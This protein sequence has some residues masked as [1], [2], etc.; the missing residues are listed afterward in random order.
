MSVR[1]ALALSRTPALGFVV[2]GLYWGG[3]ATLVP[4]LKARI[5]AS[6]AQFGLL[7]L[8]TSIGLL[9]T[10]VLAPALDRA[11]GQ[12][13]MV[14]AAVAL[15]AAFLAPGLVVTPLGFFVAMIFCGMASGMLDVIMNARVSELETAHARPL[16]NANHGVFSVAYACAA[17]GTGLAREAALPPVAVFLVI[18]GL[19]LSF[20]WRMRMAPAPVDEAP[21]GA[22]GF[23]YGVVLLCGAIVLVAFMTEASVEA[24]SALHIERTLGGRA[25]EGALGPAML[26]ITMAVGR[27]GGQAVSERMSDLAVIFAGCALA[28]MGVSFVALAQVTWVAY[29]GFGMM[30]LGVSAIGPIGL[31]LVGRMVPPHVRTKAISRA[32]VMGFFGFFLA[33]AAMGVISEGFG[34]R[35]AF[36]AIGVLLLALIPLALEIRRRGP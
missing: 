21:E 19:V 3:L 6:D 27:F 30:G 36:A 26:G 20:A 28:V 17:L 8:G 9:T 34:L 18:G 2:V 4:E 15:A 31:A 33:P 7:L 12:W 13:S 24:W 32:A 14:V 23:P 5:G 29:A 11:M 10:M 1:T 25:A 22:D 35:V 16:M